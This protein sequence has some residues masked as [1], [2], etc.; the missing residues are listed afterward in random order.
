MVNKIDLGLAGYILGIISIISII[1]TP[2]G[3]L[4]FGIVGFVLSKKE[5]TELAKKGKKLNVIGIILNAIF[6][7]VMLALFIL[8][9]KLDVTMPLA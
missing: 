5:K 6:L 8:A 3:G 2:V 7:I 1:T 4:V 9:S